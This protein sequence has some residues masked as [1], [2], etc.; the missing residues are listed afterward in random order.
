MADTGLLVIRVVLGVLLVGHGTQKLFGWFGGFGLAG[1]GGWMHS[2]GHRPGKLM[3]M[4]A[5]LSEAGG[6]LLL[7]LGFLDP[8]GSAVVVGV[9]L[10]AATTHWENG[11]W[12]TDGGYELPFFYAVTAAGLAFTGPGRYSI[13]HAIGWSY[14]WPY[15]VAA[16]G[17]GVVMA[18]L[19]AIRGRLLLGRDN[20]LIDVTDRV[21]AETHINV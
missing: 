18:A 2:I 14:D 1:T 9:M 12:N 6:G 13:D 19:T 15:A 20:R 11:I 7:A 5:G 4:V 21:P 10:T 16:V 3:A 17:V 8:L